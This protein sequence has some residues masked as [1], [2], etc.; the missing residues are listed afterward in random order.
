[1]IE[2]IINPNSVRIK[3]HAGYDEYGK[4]IVCAAISTIFQLSVLGYYKLA[5]QYP[6][7]ITIKEE[8]NE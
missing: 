2:I 7:F 5:E 4:D 6:E 3:G 8:N 1:M